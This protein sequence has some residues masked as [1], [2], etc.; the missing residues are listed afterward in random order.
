[1]QKIRTTAKV[2]LA[3]KYAGLQVREMIILE[4]KAYLLNAAQAIRKQPNTEYLDYY[5]T[6]I[7]TFKLSGQKLP[8]NHVKI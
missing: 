2:F 4:Q 5:M 7:S 3:L 8:R 6:N 1:M